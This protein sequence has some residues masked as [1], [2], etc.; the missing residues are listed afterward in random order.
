M[1]DLGSHYD[2]CCHI[3]NFVL[4]KS[5]WKHGWWH[6]Q[7]SL[8]RPVGG[9]RLRVYFLLT[10][11]HS[12]VHAIRSLAPMTAWTWDGALTMECTSTSWWPSSW[13]SSSLLSSCTV[14]RLLRVPT[15]VLTLVTST[16]PLAWSRIWV[17]LLF[18]PL[19]LRW[20]RGKWLWAFG[21]MIIFFGYFSYVWGR[22]WI[23][24][25]CQNW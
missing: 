17:S 11:T 21:I 20:S 25:L 18:S 16:S 6:V 19:S 5:S 2:P 12:V 23:L 22:D 10:Y 7:L 15:P 24:C 1:T 8:W 9:L 4:L 3:C 14:M 13:S